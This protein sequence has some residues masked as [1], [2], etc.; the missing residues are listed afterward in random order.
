MVKLPATDPR[1]EL[2]L[3]RASNRFRDAV[4]YPVHQVVGDHIWL[5][6]DGTTTLLLPSIPVTAFSLSVAGAVLVQGTDYQLSR[7]NGVVRKVGG[8][9]KDGLENI[10]V[11]YTHGWETIPGGIEDAVLEQASVQATQLVHIQRNDSGPVGQTFGAQATV[12]VTQKWADAVNK[13]A[14]GSGDRS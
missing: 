9:W 1:V 14:I 6:G 11:T 12:G 13:Y 3:R 10:E 2:A 4:G 5:D 7:K 8:V